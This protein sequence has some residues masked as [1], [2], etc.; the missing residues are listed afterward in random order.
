LADPKSRAKE[1]FA[2]GNYF[3]ALYLYGLVKA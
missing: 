1:A 2:D 3:E